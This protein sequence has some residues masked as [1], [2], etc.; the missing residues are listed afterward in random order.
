MEKKQE[1]VKGVQRHLEK[2]ERKGDWE[3]ERQQGWR[4]ESAIEKRE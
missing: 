4:A 3:K 2:E 1:P